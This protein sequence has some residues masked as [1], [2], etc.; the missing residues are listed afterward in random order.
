MP[1]T[2]SVNI[3]EFNLEITDIVWILNNGTAVRHTS[4]VYIITNSSLDAPVG[5]VSL[6]VES[7]TS[8]VVYGGIYEVTVTNPAGTDTSTF[9][10]SV[11]SK[12]IS[13]DA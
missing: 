6:S 11:T 3:T 9:N 8:P 1:L 10:V 12:N 2:P 5:T 7:V 4:D 13:Y